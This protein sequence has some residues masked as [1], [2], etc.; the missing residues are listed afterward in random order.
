MEKAKNE[1]IDLFEKDNMTLINFNNLINTFDLPII[2]TKKAIVKLIINDNVL[3][4]TNNRKITFMEK[5]EKYYFK[6]ALISY[7]GILDIKTK[8]QIYKDLQK[9]L[10]NED[11]SNKKGA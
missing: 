9:Q 10:N 8:N 4:L 6:K 3:I 7:V 2:T 1:N 5:N 11:N